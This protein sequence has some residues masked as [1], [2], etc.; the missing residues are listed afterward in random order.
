MVLASKDIDLMRQGGK[1]L[2]EVLDMLVSEAREG[3]LPTA[4]DK[5]AREYVESHGAKP[6]FLGFSGFPASVCVS[7]GSQVVH[8]I[9]TDEP[10]RAGELVG[11]DFGVLYKGLYTDAART[12]C[13]DSCKDKQSKK[14]LS[15]V[16]QSFYEGMKKV[17]SGA[18]VGDIGNAVQTYVEFQGFSVIRSLVGHGVGKEL[19]AEPNVPNFGLPHTGAQ[20]VEG[21]TIAVEP[22]I[23]AG[24]YHVVTEE[25]GWAVRTADNS[26]SAHFEN[27]IVVTKNG[28]E[29]LTK[30]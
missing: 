26:L 17:R 22:M 14:L 28:Y 27:T 7:R 19:H 18:Y 13:I 6:A 4:L 24:T 5:K 1:L 2:A 8:G 29:I 30:T 16:E 10:L 15:V 11:F 3:V 21:M 9:P 25:D 20:L 23:A 12:T